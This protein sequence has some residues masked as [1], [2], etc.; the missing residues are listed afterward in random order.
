MAPST[1][2]DIT[3]FIAHAR[4]KGMD[5]QTIRILLLSSGW[6]EK[7]IAEAMASSALD[8]PVPTPPDAGS[9]RD[10]FFH[11]LSFVSLISTVTALITL[12]FQ[13]LNRVLPDEA[14][15]MYNPSSDFS[16][17]RWSMAVVLVSF[18][19]L[20]WMARLLTR[21]YAKHPEKLGSAARRWITYLILFISACTLIGDL[22]TLLFYLLDGELTLRFVLKVL[23]VLVLCGLPFLYFLRTMRLNADTYPRSNLHKTFLG[24]GAVIVVLAFVWGLFIVGTPAYGRQQRMDDDRLNDLRQIQQEIYNIAYEGRAWEQ[25]AAPTKPVPATL[26]DMLAQAQYARP[27]I[28]DPESGVP[29]EYAVLSGINGFSL[30]ATFSLARDLQYDVFWNHAEGRSCYAFDLTKPVLH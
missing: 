1:S 23:V 2:S 18:P 4:S 22:I 30:C 25:G 28:V 14:Y 3:S 16:G 29:Y 7:D 12:F 17:I 27:D 19:L 10:T 13:Y 15:Q 26:N 5:T 8:M 21:E 6:K 20:C 24:A 11:L 9:A